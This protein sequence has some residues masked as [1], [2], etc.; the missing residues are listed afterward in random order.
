MTPSDFDLLC[1]GASAEETRRLTKMLLEWSNGDENGFPTQIA[2]LTRAN[3]RVAAN[4]PGSVDQAR[5]ALERTF[6][7]VND[8]HTRTIATSEAALSAKIEGLRTVVEDHNR[9]SVTKIKEMREYVTQV[10][11]VAKR[12]RT[13]LEAGAA[14]WNA[15]VKDFEDSTRRLNQIV[16][17]L[18]AKPWRSHWVMGVLL[19]LAAGAIG[20]LVAFALVH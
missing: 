6:T 8:Q 1:A 2:L 11:S 4:V 15:A 19:I 14:K 9:S 5:K 17:D 3:L 20:Y 12:T 16:A 13:E 18:Q 10:E 7:E